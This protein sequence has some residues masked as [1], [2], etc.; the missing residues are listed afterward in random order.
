[1]WYMNEEREMLQSMARELAVTE[2]RP[3]INT[4][5]E[6]GEFPYEIMKKIGQ[7]GIYGLFLPEEVGGL[8]QRWVD[9]GVCLEELGKESFVIANAVCSQYA[10]TSLLTMLG[11]EKVNKQVLEPI[12]RGDF[13]MAT[14]QCEPAGQT[15]LHDHKTHFTVDPETNEIVLNGGKIF[16][17][18]AGAAEYYLVCAKT[19]DPEQFGG[20][21]G[22]I[23]VHKDTPG[24]TVG[25]IEHKIGWNGSSTG[26]MF[27]NNVRVPMENLLLVMDM[28]EDTT[29]YGG[30]NIGALMAVSALGACEGVFEKTLENA[31]SR[32]HGDASIFDSYQAMRHSFAELKMD[33]EL[34]RG[35]AY[36][37]L[38]ALDNGDA[39]AIEQAWV[40][41]VKAARIFEHVAS[42]CIVLNG[43]NGVIRENGIERY[44]RDAKLCSIGCFALP[45]I[46][47]MIANHLE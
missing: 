30:G 5:E 36:G 45:H 6:T 31:R 20:E 14:S 33:I 39:D 3:F 42:E 41:K 29:Y 11:N 22:Y 1:M 16:T 12:C 4:M 34:L 25:H 37:V 26:Q 40:A 43:G 32:M 35:L 17:T 46:T 23:L 9:L 10:G 2:V 8:G 7:A 15:R 27:Y 24:L 47:E 21:F 18:N 13:V 28:D 44:L 19:P 38:T